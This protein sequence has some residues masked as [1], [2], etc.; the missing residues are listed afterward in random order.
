MHDACAWLL[1]LGLAGVAGRAL[2]LARESERLA[3]DKAK[4]VIGAARARLRRVPRAA[5]QT[6]LVGGPPAALSV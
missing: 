2:R 4:V 1:D 5:R 3:V 6:S